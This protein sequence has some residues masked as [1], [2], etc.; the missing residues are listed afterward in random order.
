[1]EKYERVDVRDGRAPPPT[2]QIHKALH[3]TS[4][5]QNS[6]YEV[7][8]SKLLPT[9][10]SVDPRRASGKG[11]GKGKG[12]EEKKEKSEEKKR[13]VQIQRST[14]K[15]RTRVIIIEIYTTRP[16]IDEEHDI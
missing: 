13:S 11:R 9:P 16:T 15:T 2:G 5:I 6:N 12:K 8:E 14:E 3:C 7:W 10:P 4:T 1:M